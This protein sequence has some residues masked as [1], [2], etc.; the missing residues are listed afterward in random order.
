MDKKIERPAISFSQEELF[1]ILTYLKVPTLTGLD[2]RVLAQLPEEQAR[3]VLS[4]AERALIAR[5]AV[6]RG[7]E[8]R[9]QL[10]TV[11][12]AMVGACATPERSLIVTRNRPGLPTE[13]YFYHM[14]RQMVVLHTLPMTAIHQFIMLEDQAAVI[15]SAMSIATL[16]ATESVIDCPAGQLP[17][18]L[19]PRTRDAA[20]T[21]AANALQ[22]LAESNLDS[23]TREQLAQTFANLVSNTTFAY[24]SQQQ[25]PESKAAGF[26]LLTGRN[27]AWLLKPLDGH[28][29]PEKFVSLQPA[30]QA[31]I[32][33][34]LKEILG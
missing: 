7:P 22:V 30:S 33:K 20:E 32:E 11:V 26:T 2:I 8:N 4:V 21:D 18:A 31:D 23:R 1:G 3:L 19:L 29:A 34:M 5:G 9:F 28:R 16:D 25:S 15:R 12:L 14:A 10:E 6:V 17:E 24:I 13:A 27:G